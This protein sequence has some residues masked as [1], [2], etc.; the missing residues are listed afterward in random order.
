MKQL[1]ITLVGI[2]LSGVMVCSQV[3]AR[4]SSHGLDSYIGSAR[5]LGQ[6]RMTYWGFDLYDAKLFVADHKAQPSLALKID[7]LRSFKGDAL[8]DQTLKEML[9]L[10]V[11]EARRRQW[12]DALKEVFPNIDPG[13]SLTAIY[14][15]NVGTLFLHNGQYIGEVAGEDFSQAF[16]GIWLDPRTTAPHLRRQLLSDQCTPRFISHQ[17]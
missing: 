2:L 16:F 3:Q 1:S 17:C 4:Q 14:R 15:P 11:P 7:Y 6:G 5:L 8:R 12:A 9:Q 10:G 13:H